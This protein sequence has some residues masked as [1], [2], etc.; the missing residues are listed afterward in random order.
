MRW[1]NTKVILEWNGSSY[2]EKVVE[3]YFH[4]GDLALCDVLVHAGE[5]GGGGA[6][7]S[8]G[9]VVLITSHLSKGLIDGG[10]IVAQVQGGVKGDGGENG[11]N[12]SEY[13][14]RKGEDGGTGQTG[15]YIKII[16]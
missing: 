3:G 7:G 15:T 9:T 12:A 1:I 14:N 4:Y 13:G 8:G 16:L 11:G 2:I 10:S 5:G 6:G